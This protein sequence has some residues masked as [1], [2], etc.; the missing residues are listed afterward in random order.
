MTFGPRSYSLKKTD[1]LNNR[2]IN[3]CIVFFY[4]FLNW[5]WCIYFVLVDHTRVK[6]KDVDPNAPGSEYINANYIRQSIDETTGCSELPP[7]TNGKVYIATQGCLPTTIADFWQMVW[8]EN[9]RVIVMTTKEIERGKV[10]SKYLIIK[11]LRRKSIIY[12]RCKM[13]RAEVFFDMTIFN[14]LLNC[15]FATNLKLFNLFWIVTH[16][17]NAENYS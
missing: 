2:T 10:R 1:I 3:S 5:L 15:V 8:Q 4:F 11:R 7:E 14:R 17:Q 16:C 12:S 13:N 6:L 9:T